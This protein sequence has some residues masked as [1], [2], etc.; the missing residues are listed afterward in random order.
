M[1]QKTPFAV[2]TRFRPTICGELVTALDKRDVQ[3]IIDKLVASPNL[4][5]RF[6]YRRPLR[7]R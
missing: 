4:F 6:S 2:M 5:L 7:A 1:D 3:D